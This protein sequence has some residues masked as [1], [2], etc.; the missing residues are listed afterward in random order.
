MRRV[1][2][3]FYVHFNFTFKYEYV[4]QERKGNDKLINPKQYI[5]ASG[6]FVVF[7]T[8]T[9]KVTYRTYFLLSIQSHEI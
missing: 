2:H 7:L 1:T 6:I 3:I 5:Q 4:S 8:H 9:S